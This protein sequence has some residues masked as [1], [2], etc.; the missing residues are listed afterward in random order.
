MKKINKNII[1]G[2]SKRKKR[3]KKNSIKCDGN[4]KWC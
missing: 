2:K 4:I 3:K 1:C